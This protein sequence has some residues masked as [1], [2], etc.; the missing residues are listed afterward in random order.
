M[1][2]LKDLFSKKPM[3]QSSSSDNGRDAVPDVFQEKKRRRII[4][5][6]ISRNEK[7]FIAFN[8]FR[9][10]I[11]SELANARDSEAILYLLPWL[12]S[13]N[14]P[15]CPGYLEGGERFKVFNVDNEK[16]I[17]TRE[18][19]FKM[20]FNV[21]NPDALLKHRPGVFPVQGL[22]T[23]GSVGGVRQN[24]GS[25]CDIWV[26]FDINDFDKNAWKALV[27]KMNLIRDWMDVNLNMP[28]YFFLSEISA[29]KECRFGSMDDESSGSMQQHVLKE[30]FYRTCMVICGKT[31]LWWLCHDAKNRFS[32]EEAAAAIGSENA[33]A[34]DII[35]L[36]D[37]E[38]IEKSEYFGAALW[39][40]HKSLSCPLKS[41]LKMKLL[42]ALLDP[43]EEKLMCHQFR[44]KVFTAPPSELFPDSAVFTMARIAESYE[45][46][47]EEE[48]LGF[49]V[50][51][52]YLGSEINPFNKR[53]K[54]K[55]K[56][57]ARFFRK[58]P[59]QRQRQYEL[60]KYD[61]WK[62][63][64][65]MAFGDK[66]FRFLIGIY[67]DMSTRHPDVRSRSDEKELS[68][69]AIKISAYYSQKEYK[70]PVLLKPRASS[71]ISNLELRLN[72]GGWSVFT[73]REI[74]H[75]SVKDRDV[76]YI[77]AFIVWNDLFLENMIHMKPNPSNVTLQEVINLGKRVKTFFGTRDTVD[78]DYSNYLKSETITRMLVVVGLEKS[79]LS[80]AE[81]DFGVVYMNCWGEL[82]VRRFD[83]FNEFE[84]F[85]TDVGSRNKNIQ[86]SYYIKR[87]S[88]SYEKVIQR[89]MLLLRSTIE[90]KI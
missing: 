35:D 19:K 1:M 62:F 8:E 74:A 27:Y 71:N 17:R 68:V 13:V 55:N 67:K 4:Q 11:F 61:T 87:S 16:E 51:C 46:K 24:S 63:K 41:L 89:T 75:Q 84:H 25:D 33:W 70:I 82:F 42:E 77:I 38:R 73:A 43:S 3:E 81:I 78:I 44:E 6:I 10:K 32:Y 48:Q 12:I 64:T 53:Q 7:R 29:I 56:L 69:L 57:A 31:P 18:K 30:E 47:E 50:E 39:Q 80:K 65:Q 21:R 22:Y 59:I 88:T 54:L 20:M 79:A 2:A 86:T 72:P 40:F 90:S 36:G 49:L 83:F 76:I 9:K 60:R 34:Y 45:G 52:L 66:L 85:L 37:I 28:V 5:T 15:E 26:C 23:I 58:H 14:E